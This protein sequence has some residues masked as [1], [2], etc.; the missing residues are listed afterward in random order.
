MLTKRQYGSYEDMVRDMVDLNDIPYRRK[1]TPS[2]YYDV[3][4]IEVDPLC[5]YSVTT[6]SFMSAGVEDKFKLFEDLLNEDINGI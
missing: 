2:L 6:F 1:L 4:D 3:E 5:Y